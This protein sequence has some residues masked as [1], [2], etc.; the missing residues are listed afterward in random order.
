MVVLK[1]NRLRKSFLY[2]LILIH[3]TQL[4]LNSL[5]I[6]YIC[7]G[8][9]NYRP[10]KLERKISFS[11]NLGFKL[12]RWENACILQFIFLQF[13]CR[14]IALCQLE[15]NS[16]RF[17]WN[18]LGLKREET[19]PGAFVQMSWLLVLTSS[20]LAREQYQGASWR[21]RNSI[22]LAIALGPLDN[23]E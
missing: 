6:I 21:N 5:K 11:S 23:P 4:Q 19:L 3:I 12:L 14:A 8:G 10:V 15:M 9:W 1:E 7:H 22:S 20:F 17:S 18:Y 16:I 13:A 2:L